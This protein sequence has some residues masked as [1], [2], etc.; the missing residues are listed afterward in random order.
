MLFGDLVRLDPT[1]ITFMVIPAIAAAVCGRLVSLPA[2]LAGRSCYWCH[3]SDV[4][5]LQTYSS[6]ARGL[7]EHLGVHGR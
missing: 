3:R 7:V 5:A 1:V 2:T 4:N 6:V